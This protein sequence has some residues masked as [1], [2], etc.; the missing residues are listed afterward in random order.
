MNLPAAI[1]ARTLLGH[2][3]KAPRMYCST[4]AELLAYVTGIVLMVGDFDASGFYALHLGVQGCAYL[5]PYE[6]YT[7]DWASS[8]VDAA[9][10]AIVAM[11]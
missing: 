5:H 11:E 6:S 7:D 4:R 9:I 1:R 10:G 8:V 3:R 2:L